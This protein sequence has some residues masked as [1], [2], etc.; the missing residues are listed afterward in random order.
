MNAEII[1]L[2]IVIIKAIIII[3]IVMAIRE[4]ISIIMKICITSVHTTVFSPFKQFFQLIVLGEKF[5][6]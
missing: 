1:N 2:Y 4:H 6:N 5:W 3:V